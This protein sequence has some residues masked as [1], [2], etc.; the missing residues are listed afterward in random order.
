MAI[1]ENALLASERAGSA[2]VLQ[3]LNSKG[4]IAETDLDAARVLIEAVVAAKEFYCGGSSRWMFQLSAMR[5]VEVINDQLERIHDPKSYVGSQL[6]ERAANAVN[7]LQRHNGDHKML[8]S[9]YAQRR[10]TARME[11]AAIKTALNVA[12]ARGN[13]SLHGH[14]HEMDLF[15][16]LEAWL[17]KS[18]SPWNGCI[19]TL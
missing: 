1:S 8:V 2:R 9:Q 3:L 7:H 16:L 11:R 5:A 4:T 17:E 18:D 6:G 13:A 10:L 14:V 15:D 19:Q 12:A